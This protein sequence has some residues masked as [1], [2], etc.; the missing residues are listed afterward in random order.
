MLFKPIDQMMERVRT[1]GDSD[2][3]LF[4]ELLICAEFFTKLTVLSLVASIEDDRDNHRYRYMH[5][6]V[7]A[8]GI[9]SWV[10]VM[11]DIFTSPASQEIPAS[12]LDVHR[13]FTERVGK[14]RWQYE[15]VRELRNVLSGIDATDTPLSKK[16]DL[17]SWFRTFA[18]LRN[19]TRGHGA[20]TPA[21]C[22][23]LAPYL[24]NSLELQIKNNPIFR[25]PWAYLHQNLSG[26]YRV[27][28]LAGDLTA[29]ENL[30]T[31]AAINGEHYPN[32]IYFSSGKLR[33]AEL[34]R[35]DID[36]TDFFVP[37]GGFNGKTYEL[38]SPISDSRLN[39]SAEPYL[40]PPTDRPASETDG[41]R[42]LEIRGN[43]FSNL[44]EVPSGYVRREN[45]E[46]EVRERLLDDRH[47]IITLVGRGG[48]G[49][50]SLVLTIL[51]GISETRRYESIVWFS[52]R[53]IDL[54]SSG[55]KAVQPR[56]LTEKEICQEYSDLISSLGE[57]PNKYRMVRDM[58]SEDKVAR[59]FVFDNFETVRSPIDLY[60][61]IDMNIRLPSKAVITSRFRDF[62]A[63]FPIEVHG[64]EYSE[65]IELIRRTASSLGIREL[66]RTQEETIT[67]ESEGHPYIIKIILGEIAD[68]GRFGRPS[69][70]LARKDD[71]LDALFE[72]TYDNLSL[73]AQRIFLT[74]SGWRSTVPQLALEAVVHWRTSEGVYPESA[75]D[76]LVRMSLIERFSVSNEGDVLAVP[77]T[78]A[79]FGKKKLA[80]SE[81]L[82][83]IRDDIN[84]LQQ[85]LPAAN[86]NIRTGSHERI[87]SM[88][89]KVAVRIGDE[90][91][92]LDEIRPM[93]EFIARS[94]PEAWLFFADLESE[95]NDNPKSE[96]KYVRRFLEQ[97]P[98]GVEARNAW[99]RLL[100]ICRRMDDVV[101]VCNAF[102][103]GAAIQ[104]PDLYEISRVANYVNGNL[105]LRSEL[106]PTQRGALLSPIANLMERHRDQAAA[107][108]LSRLAWLYLN[109][110]NE[111]AALRAAEYGLRAEPGNVHCTRL[112]DRL[113][114]AESRVS[115]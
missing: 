12:F 99:Q 92:S 17:R 104:E 73:L 74:L 52:A 29:F 110:G 27:V 100:H 50:T 6:L 105:E 18:H 63:D 19:K 8:S 46:N 66:V 28:H 22:A 62:K 93:L 84:F 30:K 2:S 11:D 113:T 41:A 94:Y 70:I 111:R 91:L 89:R 21:T 82:E 68:K 31:V 96:A 48:I 102:L 7:R 112:V 79:L 51:H 15:A 80:V 14:D 53:D 57:K 81:Q 64:M 45:L 103:K 9:G 32:G 109:S 35:S 44:P 60:Q 107:D 34:I 106:D 71:I 3:T 78:A 97:K 88:F 13:A 115:P 33:Y 59:L 54:T 47:P 10:T 25:L 61:W 5:A 56:T 1:N 39:E 23:R 40:L 67:E 37:N 65:S 24:R 55:P 42:K 58:R 69:R 90:D 87:K 20:I 98:D 85:L 75:V 16:T 83:L 76:E 101:G 38:H 26:K 114:E 4:Q 43:A 77:V 86:R 72:R 95:V 108:D 49:K 36:V